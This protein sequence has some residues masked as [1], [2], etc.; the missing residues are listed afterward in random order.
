MVPESFD[1]TCKVTPR[2]EKDHDVKDLVRRSEEVEFSRRESF[3]GTF[4]V[5]VSIFS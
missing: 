2:G 1:D 3:G 4:S 5:A